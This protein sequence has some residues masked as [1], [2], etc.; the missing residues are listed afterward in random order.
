[1]SH[2]EPCEAPRWGWREVREDVGA[3]G[4]TALVVGLNALA[5]VWPGKRGSHG[6]E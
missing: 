4:V 3:W 1:M 5:A 6:N 2:P